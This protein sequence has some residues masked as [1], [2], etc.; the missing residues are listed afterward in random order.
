MQWINE[1]TRTPTLGRIYPNDDIEIN[2][3]EIVANDNTMDVHVFCC[4]RLTQSSLEDPSLYLG[5]QDY[6][7][8]FAMV[9]FI[10]KKYNQDLWFR[11]THPFNTGSIIRNGIEQEDE[12]FAVK[13]PDFSKCLEYGN[14][15]N[16]SSF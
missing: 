9:S 16:L 11:G 3:S 2:S 7:H 14:K 13:K 1:K 12:Y 4:Q 10:T 6:N 5:D 15:G 8:P